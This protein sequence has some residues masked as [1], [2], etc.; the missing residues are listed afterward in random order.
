MPIWQGIN[1]ELHGQSDNV[2]RAG[3]TPKHID[4]PELLKALRF[5]GSRPA[6]YR[7]SKNTTGETVFPTPTAEFDVVSHRFAVR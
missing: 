4:V 7:R 6:N 1:V 3:L 2:L 5:D